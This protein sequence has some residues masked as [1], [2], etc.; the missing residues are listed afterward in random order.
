MLATD[1]CAPHELRLIT[2]ELQVVGLHPSGDGVDRNV[3]TRDG[4]QEP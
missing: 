3:F 2:V 1:C 4:E